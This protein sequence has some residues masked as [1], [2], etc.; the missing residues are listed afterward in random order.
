MVAIGVACVLLALA[1]W[2]LPPPPQ[3][4]PPPTG[5]YADK[6]RR[7]SGLARLRARRRTSRF[8]WSGEKFDN[9]DIY[10]TLVGSMV[11]RRLTTDPA[12]DYTPSWSPDGRRIAFLRRVG[13]DARI[14]VISALGGPDQKVSD[15]PVGV[16]MPNSLDTFQITWSPDGR[17]ISRRP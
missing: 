10:V 7:Q 12:E 14:H 4:E 1:T 13:Y 16:T 9:T 8:A 2:L 6:A 17:W 5:A 11:V 15:F 3:P